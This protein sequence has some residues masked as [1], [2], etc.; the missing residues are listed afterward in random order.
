[1]LLALQEQLEE[2]RRQPF[3]LFERW[4]CAIPPYYTMSILNV[5]IYAYIYYIV[6]LHLFDEYYSNQTKGLFSVDDYLCRQL[7]MRRNVYFFFVQVKI[8]IGPHLYQY[9]WFLLYI[10]VLKTVL[11]ICFFLC[12]SFPL[13][14]R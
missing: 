1:M 2:T 8:D 11:S 3:L 10:C 13:T 5:Y 9:Q 12:T 7:E 14:K 4:F 6:Y